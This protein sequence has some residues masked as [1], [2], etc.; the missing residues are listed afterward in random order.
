M[1]WLVFDCRNDSLFLIVTVFV[2]LAYTLDKVLESIETEPHIFIFYRAGADENTILKTKENWETMDNIESIIYTS[3]EEALAEFKEYN[4]KAN[5]ISAEAIRENVLPASLGI[6]LKSIDHAQTIIDL[7][8]NEQATNDSV[9]SVGYSEIVIQNIKDIA[10]IVRTGGVIILGLLIVVIF[11]FTLI[12]TEFKIHNRQEEIGIMQLVGGGLWYIRLPFILE[13]MIY[14][15]LGAILSNSIIGL[16]IYATITK[17]NQSDLIN[18]I[19]RFFGKLNWPDFN[20]ELLGTFLAVSIGI[21]AL[22]GIIN[23]YIAI[24]RYIK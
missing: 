11:L 13:S 14:G 6:R 10:T 22:I 12:T 4:S 15:M 7:V 20:I 8:K 23:S 2:S 21:G 5:P 1:A 3:E 17:Y 18:F 9:L 19:H 16:S 24:K